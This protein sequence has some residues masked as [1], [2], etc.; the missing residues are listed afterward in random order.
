MSNLQWKKIQEFQM[1]ESE[2]S[3]PILQKC[4]ISSHHSISSSNFS[5]VFLF[6]NPTRK[7]IPAFTLI[8]LSLIDL[9]NY[10][11][12][13][14]K[15]ILSVFSLRFLQFLLTFLKFAKVSSSIGTICSYGVTGIVL[16][17][18]KLFLGVIEAAC[19]GESELYDL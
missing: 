19:S 8:D 16:S 17:K 5:I 12:E 11:I 7:N 13:I 9:S 6:P 10:W 18:T 15:L 3:I 14:T 2:C 1:Q 4:F